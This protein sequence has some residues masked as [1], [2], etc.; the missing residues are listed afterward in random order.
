MSHLRVLSLNFTHVQN[1]LL[2]GMRLSCRGI[3]VSLFPVNKHSQYQW[4]HRYRPS[5]GHTKACGTWAIRFA[6]WSHCLLSCRM[7]VLLRLMTMFIAALSWSMWLGMGTL[8]LMMLSWCSQLTVRSSIRANNWTVGSISGS[9]W[10][11]HLTCATKRSTSYQVVSF[12][13]LTSWRTWTRL[14][15]LGSTT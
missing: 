7:E 13:V 4:G 15:I 10:I 9:C 11:L 5:T 6:S 8:H 12:H 1:A 3:D 14:C 2:P